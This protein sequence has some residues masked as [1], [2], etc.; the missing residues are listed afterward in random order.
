MPKRT[1]IQKIMIIGAGPIVVGQGCEFDY[2]GTQAC[3]ALKQEGYEIVLVNSNPATIMT[4]PELSDRTYIEPITRKACEAIIERE[5]PQALLPTVGGQTALNVAVELYEAGVLAKY[6]VELLGAKIGA[7]KKAEDRALFKEAALAV[8]LD[9][10]KSSV[11]E[12][13]DAA[14]TAAKELGFPII[15]RPAFTLGG[16]GGG[17]AFNQDEFKRKIA[18]ALEISP[19]H[20]VLVEESVIGWKEYEL[21]V[22]RD[23]KDNVVIVCSIEN[24]DPMGVHTGDSIT[25]APA[26]TLSDR[27]YQRMRAAAIRLIREI[28]VD[29]GGSNIQFAVN[30]ANGRMIVIEM[31]PRVSRSSALA[32]KATG[33]PIAKIASKLAVGYT[34]DE[35]GNDITGTTP[36]SFEPA[37]DYIVVK[38]PRFDFE[39]FPD[40]D[41]TLTTQM[42]SV[43]EALAIGRTFEE[44]LQK[45]LRSLETKRTGFHGS[46]ATD[47]DAVK[48]KLGTPNAER[49]FSIADALV[50]GMSVEDIARLTGIQPWFLE[51]M[52]AIV[53]Y[54]AQAKKSFTPS[55]DHLWEAKRMGFSDAQISK[56]FGSTEE[57]TRELRSRLGVE[58][59]YLQ[60]D[61]CAA[62][63]E[64]QTPYLYGSFETQSDSPPTGKDK[65]LIVGGGP[66]RIGQGIEFDYCCVHGAM[67]L[68]ADGVEVV[69]VNCNPSTVSTDYDTSDRLYIEPLTLEHVLDICAREK[70]R[71]VVVQFGGHTPLGLAAGLSKAGVP[72]LGTSPEDIDRAEDRL[73]FGEVLKKLAIPAPDWGTART[74]EECK[75]VAERVGFPVLV[76]PSYVLGGRAMEIVYDGEHLE[77]LFQDAVRVSPDH[78]VL[79]DK[80]L[81]DAIEIDVDCVSDGTDVVIAGIMEHVEEAGIHS[82]DSSC[83]LPPPTLRKDQTDAVVA[84]ARALARELSV[85]GFLNVQFAVRNDRVYVLEANPRASR[86]VPFASKATGVAWAKVAVRALAGKSLRAQ[87]IDPDASYWKTEHFSVKE[88]VFPFTKFLGSDIVRG[89]EMRSTGEVMGIDLDFGMAYAKSQLGA[90]TRVP[91]KGSVFVSVKNKDKR[92]AVFVAK[93][94]AHLG[95]QLVAT[96]GTAYALRTGGLEV[97]L[98][99]K[100]PDPRPNILDAIHGGEIDLVM[101]TPVGKGPRSDDYEIR[102]AAVL[103]GVHCVTTFSGMM[104]TSNALASLASRPFTVRTL[105]EY[106]AKKGG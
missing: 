16:A 75:V 102:R 70:P 92:Q 34:L 26:Q 59:T 24:I 1:D 42:K 99:G 55:H 30:P 105:Q 27:E 53:A 39:K 79:I 78:P 85:V 61:T 18:Y 13:M 17:I 31:N 68:R 60:V 104:A 3:K 46:G 35:L 91:S 50:L 94:L 82:G 101:N 51:R 66:N 44:A 69:M 57:A 100:V 47:L 73:R 93:E 83:V 64:A 19:T 106:Q 49:I 15:L 96:E 28:G 32:S 40:A 36:A 52:R 65:I 58:R 77:Q 10:P 12:N 80:Y 41:P 37:I 74:F 72:I 11:V 71:G 103:K 89:P 45:V 33:F 6:E 4:D 7:I 95:F 98:V 62:E 88:S 97:R 81:E 21:E 76:R 2:S 48:R 54:D 20:Q 25:V 67:A 86:T 63:F 29:T 84:H 43:G 23:T 38:A 90:G 5:R 14:L 56:W 87:G 22:V 8:G 9:L